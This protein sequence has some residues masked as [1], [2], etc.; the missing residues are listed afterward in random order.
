M[1]ENEELDFD[2]PYCVS[3]GACGETGCCSPFVCLRKSISKNKD[4]EYG[5]IYLKEIKLYYE[6]G[7]K[8]YDLILEKSNMENV[9][10]VNKIYD[11]LFKKIYGEEND[12]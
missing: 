12:R 7:N 3:C 9:K 1:S 8:L 11:E 5:E 2:N 6:L 10:I 4:C